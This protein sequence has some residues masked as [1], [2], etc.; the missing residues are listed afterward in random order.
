MAASVA[1]DTEKRQT[2][3]QEQMDYCA[4]QHADMEKATAESV[5]EIG[6]DALTKTHDI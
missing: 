6:T 3:V 5:L 1:A 4:K 2:S